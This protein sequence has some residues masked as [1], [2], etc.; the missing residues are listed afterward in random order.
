MRL[1]K[2]D[3]EGFVNCSSMLVNLREVDLTTLV[4]ADTN[5]EELNPNPKL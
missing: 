5:F 1:R 4:I 3:L 2:S